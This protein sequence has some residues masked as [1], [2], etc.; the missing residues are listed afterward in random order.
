MGA[1]GGE[2]LLLDRQQRRSGGSGGREAIAEEIDDRLLIGRS[3]ATGRFSGSSSS[4]GSTSRSSSRR[5]IEAKQ[6]SG[7]GCSCS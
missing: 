3:I 2:D 1:V 5:S 4:A 6:I 7:I